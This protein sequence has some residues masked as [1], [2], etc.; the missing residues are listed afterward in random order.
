MWQGPR[1]FV[2]LVPTYARPYLPYYAPNPHPERDF[3]YLAP[4][5]T[6]TIE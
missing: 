1:N 2:A 6:E 4:E 3:D 5:Q